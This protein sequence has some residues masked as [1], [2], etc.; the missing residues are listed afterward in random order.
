[1]VA[2]KRFNEVLSSLAVIQAYLI[3]A[4]ELKYLSHAKASE[5]STRIEEIQKQLHGWQRWFKTQCLN[6]VKVQGQNK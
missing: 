3:L 4:W 1:M 2:S 6:C 5:L